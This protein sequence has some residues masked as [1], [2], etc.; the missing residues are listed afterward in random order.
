MYAIGE[1]AQRHSGK[2]RK[3]PGHWVQEL[4]YH[5]TNPF[6]IEPLARRGCPSKNADMEDNQKLLNRR[7]GGCSTRLRKAGIHVLSSGSRGEVYPK[8]RVKYV[9]KSEARA[10]GS[11]Y[12]KIAIL[13]LC[14]ENVIPLGLDKSR[15]SWSPS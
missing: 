4:T 3:G 10:N 14:P 13:R 2:K 15:R 1:S 5:R 12:R 7:G 6:A 8:R 11:T 9:E